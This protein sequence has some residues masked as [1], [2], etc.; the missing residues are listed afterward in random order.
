MSKI[1]SVNSFQNAP[2]IVAAVAAKSQDRRSTLRAMELA[3]SRVPARRNDLAPEIALARRE[4]SELRPASRQV[5][6]ANAAHTAD[7]IASIEQ[8][9][10]CA[11]PLVTDNGEIIDG[12]ARIEAAKA[13]ALKEIPCIVIG[14]LSAKDVRRYR[15][16]A[17]LIQEKG[18]W[19]FS[20]LEVEFSELNIEFDGDLFIPG[21]EPQILDGFLQERLGLADTLSEP[22]L[23]NTGPI[24]TRLGD[25][26]KL[27]PH[28]LACADAR[29]VSFVS[30][31]L[32]A[33]YGSTQV[34]LNFSDLP[35]NVKIQG[36]VSGGDHRE[37]VMASG[38]MS[39]GEFK[40]FLVESLKVIFR[41]LMEGGLAMLFMDWRGLRI[42]LEAG[43]LVGFSLLNVVIWAKTNAGMGSLYR[44]Q[45]EF[46]VVFKKGSAP[47]INN[48][49]LGKHGRYR[50]NL[51]TY[52]GASSLGSDARKQLAD[53]PTPKPVALLE[54]AIL[55]VTERGDLVFDSFAGS[56]STLIAADR[57]GRN[58][59]GTEL[60]PGYC[61][62]ILRRWHAHSDVSATLLETG[63]TFEEVK[64]RRIRENAAAQEAHAP[65]PPS[66]DDLDGPSNDQL[67]G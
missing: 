3:G 44:S 13:L 18:E 35:Y 8:F 53:H 57:A 48:V 11:P 9:G 31:I 2:G 26:W 45:H 30:R 56:G 32:Q 54:D 19:D 49:E 40:S 62:V 10:V 5:R 24:I 1:S 15:I 66:I 4:I 60:D 28:I 12:H 37:F 29:D 25:V 51:W 58:F 43:E 63:E 61:D 23:N 22:I 47:H 7:V 39:D 64:A 33:A 6:R 42:L 34:R 46:V 36:H 38:E 52:P 67:G 14:H 65:P 41:P 21:I 17:N 16:S 50:T 20:A 55:D 59:G 27:G